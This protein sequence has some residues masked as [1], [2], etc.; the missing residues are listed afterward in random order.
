[1]RGGG[2]AGG[3]QHP[4]R[5]ANLGPDAGT[6][7]AT[8]MH[9]LL[10]FYFRISICLYVCMYIG[11]LFYFLRVA[12]SVGVIFVLQ[13]AEQTQARGLKNSG[14]RVRVVMCVGC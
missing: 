8:K 9:G 10:Y 11:C 13:I 14:G 3:V 12:C 1:M 7:S 2:Q 5:V 4:P 6:S